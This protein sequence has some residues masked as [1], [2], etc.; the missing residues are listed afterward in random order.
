MDTPSPNEVY[1]RDPASGETWRRFPATAADQVER[2][3]VAARAA[4]HDWG[5]RPLAER[6]RILERFRQ[7]VYERR[8]EIAST[9][10]HEN[11]KPAAEAMATEVATTLDFVRFYCRLAPGFFAPQRLRS[12]SLALWRK[13]IRIAHEAYGVVAVISPWNYPFMLPAGIIIPALVAGNVVLLK[14][15]ELTPSSAALLEDLLLSS[16][17]PTDVFKV[18]QGDGATGRALAAGS[19][20]KLFFTGSVATGR[21]VA[22][23]C[24]ERLVPCVLELGGSDPALVLD[25]ADVAHA[26]SGITWGRFSN[27]GQT[28]VAP[29]RVFVMDAVY[30]AFVAAMQHRVKSLRVGAM[31]HAEYD[32]GALIRP[33]QSEALQGQLDD[34][35]ALGARQISSQDMA[36][37]G[38]GTRGAHGALF[39]PTLLL[40]VSADARAMREE[41]FGP[42]LPIV[43]VESVEEAIR[44]ANA[45]EFGLSASVW[46]R[47]SERAISV[48]ARLE[49][50]TV[51]INDVAL[52]AGMAEV[53]HGGVK[54]SGSGRSHGVAGLEECVRTKTVV[55]DV[56]RG[57][58][59]GWWFG[60]GPQSLTRID[61]YVRL[62][63]GGTLWQRLTG[64]VG[65]LKLLF[66]PERP[67]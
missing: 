25:D 18:L 9:I 22:L 35:L 7:L 62:A 53:P 33:A 54:A 60:Y 39:A 26:A 56:F 16:G 37:D 40:D 48:A 63:H 66:R 28:C 34:A 47:N 32:V 65:T 61:A 5:A 10:S 4:K 29:K 41:T 21:R 3:I 52:V 58:R 14:P 2:A 12:S 1:S 44:L 36:S 51:V 49:A 13:R 55:D 42:L 27:S 19:V 38:S 59:Q 50:G 45:S 30:D 20:D 17:V 67:I 8:S 23:A 15:S 24:A 31:H 57:W 64:V 11:G 46:S 43:R 6:L